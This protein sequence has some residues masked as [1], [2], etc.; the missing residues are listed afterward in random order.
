MI[1]ER[2]HNLAEVDFPKFKI[3]LSSSHFTMNTTSYEE[4]KDFA[5]ELAEKV[6]LTQ[7]AQAYGIGYQ[8]HLR[9]VSC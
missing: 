4:I 6:R 9:R 8:D 5:Y 2:S 1:E 3:Q 7:M